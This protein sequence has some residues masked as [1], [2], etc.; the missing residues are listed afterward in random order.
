MN[1]LYHKQV[2][3]SQKMHLINVIASTVVEYGMSIVNYTTPLLW[4]IDI[5]MK[6]VVKHALQ[7]RRDCLSNWLW[8]EMI[9][10]GMGLTC[11]ENMQDTAFLGCMIDQVLKGL[12]LLGCCAIINNMNC[13]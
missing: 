12:D 11:M 2:M 3:A 1:G 9:N 13:I 4:K 5:I 6:K 10:G 7:I 8:T